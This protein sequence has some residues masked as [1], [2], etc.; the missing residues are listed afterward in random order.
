MDLGGRGDGLAEAFE[1]ALPRGAPSVRAAD[2]IC[3]RRSCPWALICSRRS[4]PWAAFWVPW[5]DGRERSGAARSAG[6]NRG[7]RRGR[8][9]SIRER[10]PEANNEPILR[11]A[12]GN[13]GRIGPAEVNRIAHYQTLG[14]DHSVTLLGPQRGVG[15]RLA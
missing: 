5:V 4:L 1:Q 6:L 2:L 8:F 14:G 10:S 3:A 11:K 7:R 9:G 13:T 15:T 12:P